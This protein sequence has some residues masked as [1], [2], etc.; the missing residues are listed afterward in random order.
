MIDVQRIDEER[1]GACRGQCRCNLRSDV[2]T[3][4][5]A[6]DNDLPLTLHNQFHSAV[7]VFVHLRYQV[8]HCLCLVLDTLYSVF[9]YCHFMS[10]YRNI[11]MSK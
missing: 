3:L 8:K 5:Y 10:K 1:R 6:S 4:T 9:S 2:S 7:E 11:V